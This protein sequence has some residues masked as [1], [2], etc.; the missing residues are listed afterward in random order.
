LL[1]SLWVAGEDALARGEVPLAASRFR[2]G[3]DTPPNRWVGIYRIDLID[4]LAKVA[5]SQNLPRRALYLAGAAAAARAR[6]GTT[7]S[8]IDREWLEA[9]LAPAHQA[10]GESQS[11]LA[12]ATGESMTLEQAV[13][14]A[15]G[16]QD[17]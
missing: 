6:L 2:E 11:S 17:A 8:P 7:S 12:Y 5:A 9:G 13:A 4:G 1:R 3:L 15:L 16:D 10:L 14:Y